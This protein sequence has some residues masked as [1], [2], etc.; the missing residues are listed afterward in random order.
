MLESF[1]KIKI[2][3]PKEINKILD[4]DIESFEFLKKDLSLN[5][6][7]F[8][9]SLIIAYFEQFMKEE[10]NERELL[11]IQAK[12][13]NLVG[14]DVDKF[15]NQ[16]LKMYY[17]NY[18]K[19][20]SYSETISFRPTKKSIYAI[21]YIENNLLSKST[22]SDFFR[23]LFYRYCSLPQYQRER[24]I[25]K[26]IYQKISKAIDDRK[27]VY[28]ATRFNAG[29]RFSTSPYTFS[30]VKEET[31]NYL[32]CKDE[33]SYRTFRLSK[34]Q[35]C[36]ITDKEA[37]FDEKDRSH[38]ERMMMYGPQYLYLDNDQEA[39]VILTKKGQKYFKS[40]YVY[41]PVVD[42]IEGNHYF[43]KCSIDQLTQYFSRFGS[44]CYVIK[45]NN[46]RMRL[47][48][49]YKEAYRNLV[50]QEKELSAKTK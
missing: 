50:K 49:Y 48:N 4:R 20:E 17:N 26:D 32:L 3:V 41:R 38:F 18:Q 34:I 40:F 30:V 13:Y 42:R 15:I 46:L 19:K 12:K 37:V 8:I 1:E 28:I 29:N 2:A 24:I 6:N 22:L 31:Y 33:K 7:S 11:I 5:K 23:R 27:Q 16:V 9:N 21:D 47:I 36:I 35:D 25:F 44:E 43:F 14:E 39:E 10:K 45:P